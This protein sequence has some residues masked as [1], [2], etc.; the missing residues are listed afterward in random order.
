MKS[1]KWLLALMGVT[2][3]VALWSD[4]QA[5]SQALVKSAFTQ[6]SLEAV[7]DTQ[8]VVTDGVHTWASQR[9]VQA[10]LERDALN[11]KLRSESALRAQISAQLDS[12][13]GSGTVSAEPDEDPDDGVQEYEFTDYEKPFSVAM[14]M[15]VN[16]LSEEM[17]VEWSVKPDPI[18]LAI[19]VECSRPRP[20]GVRPASL[21]VEAPKFF[22][23]RVAEVQQDPMVCNAPLVAEPR[24]QRK[25]LWIGT[26]VGATLL[27]IWGVGQ[28]NP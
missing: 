3:I 17:E 10:N 25:W 15:S 24:D 5:K 22:V 19:R 4:S 14:N 18:S 1:I 28:L 8:R 13:R 21:L 20:N 12:V 9:I 16:V 23:V 2:F 27:A 26:G 6:D 7:L 11:K